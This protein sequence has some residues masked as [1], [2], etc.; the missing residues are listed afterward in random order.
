M[1]LRDGIL[2][3]PGP[4]RKTWV[5]FVIKGVTV[6]KL[7]AFNTPVGLLAD[8]LLICANIYTVQS[9]VSMRVVGL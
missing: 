3:R 9:C 4:A 8:F 2:P 5:A 7:L 1:F 6:F